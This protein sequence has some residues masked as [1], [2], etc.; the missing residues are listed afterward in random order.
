MATSNIEDQTEFIKNIQWMRILF[1]IFAAVMFVGFLLSDYLIF[2]TSTKDR[3]LQNGSSKLEQKENDFQKFLE[4]SHNTLKTMANSEEFLDK[5]GYAKPF[6]YAIS[7]MNENFM[8]LRY[9]NRFGMEEIR[10]DRKEYGSEAVVVRDSNLQNKASRYYFA[11]SVTKPLEETWYSPLDLNVENNKVQLPL[12]PTVRAM[13][14]LKDEKSKEFAG[15]LII[16]YFMK[17][18][19]HNWLKDPT[20]SFILVNHKGEILHHFDEELSWSYEKNP[21]I[22][23]ETLFPEDAESILSNENFRSDSLVSKKLEL[24]LTQSL[25]L[26]SVP[27]FDFILANETSKRFWNYLTIFVVILLLSFLLGGVITQKIQKMFSKYISNLV[28]LTKDRDLASTAFLSQ[29]GIIITDE[30]GR[31]LKA[32][33]SYQ[34]MTGWTEKELLGKSP[35]IMRSGVHQQEF[36][37]QM[38]ETIE[39]NGFWS[40]EI[41][42]KRKFGANYPALLVITKVVSNDE[43]FYVGT[44]Q[45]ITKQKRYETELLEA[46]EK[47]ETA[48]KS[49]ADFLANMSH[50]IRTPLNGIIGLTDLSLKSVQD[51]RV[52]EYM[53]KVLLSSNSLLN[54]INDI[55]D[56]SKIEAGKLHVE[57]SQFNIEEL[58]HN[59]AHLFYISAENKGITLHLKIDTDVPHNLF[60]D[61]HRLSQVVNNILGNAI[62]FTSE[63]QV[64]LHLFLIAQDGNDIQVQIDVKDTGKGIAPENISKLFQAFSQEDN[65]IT[66]EYGGT[67]LGLGISKQL[68]ELMGGKIE[69]RSVLHEGST[70]SITLPF[71]V[72]ESV[73]QE[74]DQELHHK[75]LLILDDDTTQQ[76]IIQDILKSWNVQST[77]FDNPKAA[78]QEIEVE[79]FD[80]M[81]VDW[82]MPEMDGVEF[83]SKLR[84]IGKEIPPVIMIS[85]YEKTNLLE[86]IDKH[87]LRVKNVLQKPFVS[88]TLYDALLDHKQESSIKASNSSYHYKGDILLAEDN[89][90]NQTVAIQ[91]LKQFG[92]EV[93]LA[94]DGVRAVELFQ[95]HHFDLVLM[96]LH[97]PRMDGFEAAQKISQMNK[98]V[99]IYALSAAVME[100]DRDK[101]KQS[102]MRG[103]LA[104]PIDLQA[105]EAVLSQH[106]ESVEIETSTQENKNTQPIP[107]LEGINTLSLFEHVPDH[108]TVLSLFRSFINNFSNTEKTLDPALE[109]QTLR[110]HIHSLKGVSGQIFMTQVYEIAKTMH[111]DE[112]NE[113]FMELL[114]PLSIEIQKVSKVIQEYLSENKTKVNLIDPKVALQIVQESKENLEEGSYFD[115]QKRAQLADAVLALQG[116]EMKEK[117]LTELESFNNEEV[118]LIIE[119]IIQKGNNG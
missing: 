59:I 97:M 48:A 108:D 74:I 7:R 84:E 6:F 119:E 79:D 75:H 101:T 23:L 87:Q 30:K 37:V 90:I 71:I 1:G 116:E 69:V 20:Y 42:N 4:G 51:K 26:I 112:D 113:K 94:E 109:I 118:L 2:Q 77:I 33:T 5:L 49:K 103:H 55:L 60:G 89:E 99:P 21:S 22:T 56:Y 110:D 40:G 62:K 63:G 70:F 41:Y 80:G 102:G 76:L 53:Q 82:K 61:Q 106:L 28:E 31:I 93:S 9:I 18:F 50:E 65:S 36:Y 114:N 57:S 95:M 14:P 66:R 115:A 81:I 85:A 96:D 24:P 67:G 16:N 52:Q 34:K 13:Y 68:V 100:K 107:T 32:N 73:P 17:N 46:K 29:D 78:L 8:Q 15:I 104:K 44:M 92:C 43:V 117:I 83:L 47:A 86:E 88:S 35:A 12:N 64:L 98:E 54:I 45:D 39:R 58:M 11:D 19:L 105:L 91:Y 72:D 27:N 25:I 111:D 38:W 3:I 10:V